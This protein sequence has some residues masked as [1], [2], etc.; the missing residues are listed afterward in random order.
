VKGDETSGRINGRDAVA[1]DAGLSPTSP[2]VNR[3]CCVATVDAGAAASVD[4]RRLLARARRLL[5]ARLRVSADE[6]LMTN[7]DAKRPS[8]KRVL[9]LLDPEHRLTSSAT[10]AITSLINVH[11]QDRDARKSY[12]VT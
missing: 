1:D 3:G 7:D 11:D 12:K 2:R 4:K 9:Q 8:A 5:P 6:I 10:T